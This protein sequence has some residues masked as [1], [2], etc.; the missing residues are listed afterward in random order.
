MYVFMLRLCIYCISCVRLQNILVL[1][2]L[3]KVRSGPEHP[4]LVVLQERAASCCH[5]VSTAPLILD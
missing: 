4:A 3:A 1:P 5:L 2:H